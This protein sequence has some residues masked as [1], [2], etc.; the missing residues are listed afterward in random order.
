[1]SGALIAADTLKTRQAKVGEDK[2]QTDLLFPVLEEL[3]GPW[4]S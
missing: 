3:Q 1:L 2:Q 4:P